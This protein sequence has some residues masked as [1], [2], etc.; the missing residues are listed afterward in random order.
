MNAVR[1]TLGSHVA[2][3]GCFFHLCQS[4]WRKI[5]ELGLVQAY[6]NKPDVRQFCEMIDALAFL[7]ESRHLR[8]HA[9]PAAARAVGCREWP[10]ARADHLLWHYTYVSGAVRR[11]QRPANS[12][13]IPS[14]VIRRL[15]PLFPPTVWNVHVPT[16]NGTDRTN[17]LCEAWNRGFSATVNHH[18]PSLWCVIDALQQDA[19]AVTTVLLQN[20]RGQP[21]AKRVQRSSV[22][23]Q[24]QQLQSICCD[25]R[26][27][28]VAEALSA[29]AHN[30][31]LE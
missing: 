31:R 4:N 27:K 10:A 9:V 20:A 5:Q 25:G 23:L 18:H 22:R 21:P 7:P 16:I 1:T 8:R 6:R 3:Q 19:A 13:S 26:N 24:Q 12:A 30:I 2:V 29:L 11:V 17:N 15:P 28:S 14:L